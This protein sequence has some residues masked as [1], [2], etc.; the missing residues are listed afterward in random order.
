M[1]RLAINFL[2]PSFLVAIVADGCFFALFEPLELMRL[3]GFDDGPSLAGYTVTFFFFWA[4]CTLASSL[5]FFLVHS[6]Q[7]R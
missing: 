6:V 1:L 4:A 7:E 3:A 5:T 2:W